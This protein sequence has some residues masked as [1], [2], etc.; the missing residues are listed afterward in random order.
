MISTEPMPNNKQY[1]SILISGDWWADH[2]HSGIG[3]VARVL[4]NIGLS[5]GIIEKPNWKDPDLKD[6]TKL[7]FPNLFYGVSAGQIDSM[8]QNYTPLK[9][10][11]KEDPYKPYDS[12]I[13]DRA[14]IVYTQKLKQILK[15]EKLEIP[16]II[17]GVEA[18]LRRFTH[19]DYWD[20]KIRRPLLFDSRADILV[21]GPG[22]YQ[23]KE[24]ARRIQKYNKIK[25]YKEISIDTMLNGIQGTCV[26]LNDSSQIKGDSTQL[27]THEILLENKKE[28]C[29]FSIAL[30]NNE[31]LYEPVQNKIVVQYKAHELSPKELDAMYNLPFTYQIPEKYDVL[32]MAQFSIAT[33]R[34][35]FGD[36]NF[37]SIALH[38]GTHIVSRS[39]DSIL[40]EINKIRALPNFKGVIE[41]LGGPSANM[42][43]MDCKYYYNCKNNHNCLEC[44]ALDRSHKKNIKLLQEA[45][46]QEDIKKVLVRSGIRYDLA[47]YSE[48]YIKQICNNHISGKL[49][50]AP[51]HFD[52][53]ICELMNK[54]IDKFEEFHLKFKEFN[55]NPN[56]SLTYY[57]MTAHP[58]STMKDAEF[59]K[60]KIKELG[61]KNTDSVQ[62]FTPTP[63]SISTCMYYTGLNPFTLEKIHIPYSYK[64]KKEQKRILFN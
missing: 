7:G 4:E 30:T 21:F 60:Q 11:R 5:V 22:E 44:G 45:Q 31:T 29:K 56:Q 1:D 23:L 6:F 57:F 54:P 8:L 20:N 58:G 37:C 53:R 9:K 14:T 39:I 17:G 27:Q 61:S 48:D 63:M 32:K 16:I 3:V 50:I 42:Y 15:K 34:G 38:Q 62:I 40:K 26:I 19:F 43:G 59:L 24:I 41:D 46:K 52:P 12:Q 49:K 35:C 2:P 51:E 18:S 55:P 64:E 28:F 33:H 25:E 47:T 36:C 13:P 10:E